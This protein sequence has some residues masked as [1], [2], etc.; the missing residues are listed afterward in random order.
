[1]VRTFDFMTA[2]SGNTTKWKHQTATRSQILKYL[3]GSGD[4]SLATTF[5]EYHKLPHKEQAKLKLSLPAFI[6]GYF[7]GKRSI[8]TMQRRNIIALDLDTLA[9]VD[10]EKML[11]PSIWSYYIYNTVSA[12]PENPKSRVLFFLADDIEAAYYEPFARH[13]AHKLGLIDYVDRTCYR[14]NQL[15]YAPKFLKGTPCKVNK[16]VKREKNLVPVKNIMKRL[17]LDVSKWKLAAGEKIDQR[18]AEMQLAD[19]R[20]KMG[21]IG[22]FCEAVGDIEIAIERFDLPYTQAGGLGRYTYIHGESENGL[23]IYD[24]GQHAFSYHSTDPAGTGHSLNAFD[25]VRVHMFGDGEDSSEKML[26]FAEE[27]D[28]VQAVRIKREGAL[29]DEVLNPTEGDN[30]PELPAVIDETE[31][32]AEQTAETMRRLYK[33][34]AQPVKKSPRR[35][36]SNFKNWTRSR[37][38]LEQRLT[39][40]IA[41]PWHKF[42]NIHAAKVPRILSDVILM[43]RRDF[44]AIEDVETSDSLEVELEE[45]YIEEN[46]NELKTPVSFFIKDGTNHF[47]AAFGKLKEVTKQNAEGEPVRVLDFKELDVPNFV[48][49][50][51][52]YLAG[53]LTVQNGRVYSVAKSQLEEMTPLAIAEKYQI[54]INSKTLFRADDLL[55]LL[56]FIH[57]AMKI[58]PKRKLALECIAGRDFAINLR[59]LEISRQTLDRNTSYF[60]YF[61]IKWADVADR[62][63]IYDRFLD[64]VCDDVDSL[65]N[66]KLQTLYTMQVAAR[67]EPKLNFFVSKSSVRTGKGLRHT[68]MSSLFSTKKV[69]LDGL[70]GQGFEA[71]NAWATFDGGEFYVATE[72]GIIGGNPKQERSLKVIATELETAGR[73]QGRDTSMI[74]LTGVLSIDTNEDV[75]FTPQMSSRAVNIAF[76]NRP[77]GETDTQRKKIFAPYWK[78]FTHNNHE[79]QIS[80]GLASLVHSIFYFESVGKLFEWRSVEMNNFAGGSHSFDEAQTAIFENYIAGRFETSQRGNERLFWSGNEELKA[81]YDKTY[82][83]EK[84]RR[85]KQLEK[86]GLAETVKKNPATKKAERCLSVENKKR[87]T[88]A[89]TNYKT[90]QEN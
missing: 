21:T 22:D 52:D 23:V 11:E 35:Q 17:S 67:I 13:I 78:S 47:P 72:Q 46:E 48:Q 65:H 64:M 86:I 63:P 49:A 24:E 25:L 55:E 70:A 5:A 82:R 80:A 6:G 8:Q 7:E 61:P 58:E 29:F 3:K 41:L 56:K 10:L 1:M 19:P 74:Q 87:L 73:R 20:D 40:C 79:P 14:R 62:V 28:D 26:K 9:G 59:T 54:G 76:K 89:L 34:N 75:I 42:D 15:M 60:K 27:L 37:R 43:Q 36:K 39:E 57:A 50:I 30:V 88:R 31:E 83:Y 69:D 84:A 81:I 51:T 32:R 18:A 90:E 85:D 2:K 33:I 66:A 45:P 12:T 44:S 16:F 68:V 53:K 77:D 71:A 4:K 38:E